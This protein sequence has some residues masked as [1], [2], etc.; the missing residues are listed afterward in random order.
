MATPATHVLFDLGNVV[1]RIHFD[2]CFRLWSVGTALP[3]AQLLEAFH[4]D[5]MYMKHER[6]EITGREYFEHINKALKG[7]LSYEQFVNGWSSV[8]G[9][10]VKE[11]IEF[12]QL[13]P[14]LKFYA[15]TNSN[16]LHREKWQQIYANELKHFQ[17]IYCSSQ[18]GCRKPEAKAFQLIVDELEVQSDQIVFVDDLLENIEGAKAVGLQGVHFQEPAAGIQDLKA[19]CKI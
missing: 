1:F 16:V 6:N 14:Q 19:I 8:F 15:L 9:D 2:R 3:S 11:T 13:N 5:P 18:I 12:M 4:Q 7:K 10:P 17:K